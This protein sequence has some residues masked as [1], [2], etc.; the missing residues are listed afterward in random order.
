MAGQTLSDVTTHW[1]SLP[2]DARLR[3][4]KSLLE[5]AEFL[6]MAAS[7][8]DSSDA[9]PRALAHPLAE[10]FDKALRKAI[11]E[12]LEYANR[13]RRRTLD[14]ARAVVDSRDLAQE[15][16]RMV[17][18]A[19]SRRSN[20]IQ[21]NPTFF[22]AYYLARDLSVKVELVSELCRKLRL[23][24]DHSLVLSIALARALLQ[25][26]QRILALFPTQEFVLAL[27]LDIIE[28]RDNLTNAA[29]NFVAADLTVV[30]LEQEHLM[31][32]RWDSRTRWPSP[33]W[34]DRARRASVEDPPGS[35]V[36]V[37]RP[38]GGGHIAYRGSMAP[39]S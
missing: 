39:I 26:L 21:S 33:E 2:V 11:E 7:C 19:H 25:A 1:Q 38:P 10:A 14:F 27:E 15:L 9:S 31:G 20:G 13:D 24:R 3:H 4:R 28:A 22:L 23:P 35:G 37:I 30:P 12:S 8:R 16:N 32:M 34:K 29:S 17:L 6:G 18:D 5:I 36:F